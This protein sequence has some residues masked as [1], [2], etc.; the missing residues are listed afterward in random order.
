[1][2]IP[3]QIMKNTTHSEL[4]RIGRIFFF[5]LLNG[6]LIAYFFMQARLPIPAVVQRAATFMSIELPQGATP[7]AFLQQFQE[8]DLSAE[9]L[10]LEINQH[11]AAESV[12][13]LVHSDKLATVAARLLEEY[14]LHDFE[15]ESVELDTVLKRELAAVGFSYEWVSHQVLVGPYTNKAVA[16]AWKSNPQQAQAI[17]NPL[18]SQVGYAT[19]LTDDRVGKAG[20]VVQLLAQPQ[21]PKPSTATQ[22][23]KSAGLTFPTITDTEVITALNNYREIHGLHKLAVNE[24]LCQYAEKRVQDLIAFGGLDNHAGFRADFA[25]QNNLP[26][27]IKE[28]P[29]GAIGENLAHQYCKNMTTNES[30]VAQTGT[31]LIEWCFDSSTK[32]HREAQLSKNFSNVC[33]RHGE[34]MYVVIFGE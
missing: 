7:A 11:R 34:G 16:T 5:L 29:G 13:A 22:P 12:P 8:P 27:G 19:A 9:G 1:M 30:F 24:Q 3:K 31:A 21:K 23:K 28:Y 20:V 32:G 2:V 18:F 33:V 10:L 26:V 25:D 4:A 6:V 17:S 14:R 15:V